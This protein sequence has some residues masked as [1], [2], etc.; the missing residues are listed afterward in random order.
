MSVTGYRV[1][2]GCG[3]RLPLGV[4]PADA[5]FNASPECLHIYGELTGYTVMRRDEAFI[6]QHLVDTYAAQHAGEGRPTIGPA[7]ALIGLYLAV[8]KGYTGKQVQHMHMLLARR[9]K[10]WP[11]FTLPAHVGPL[12]ALDVLNAA[13]GSERDETLMRWAHSVWEAWADEHER[14][15]ALFAHVMAD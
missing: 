11:A 13:P 10:T 4:G 2:P 1:C 9:S 6:H 3:A 15:R 14:V 12:T 7:F 5:R 8:E